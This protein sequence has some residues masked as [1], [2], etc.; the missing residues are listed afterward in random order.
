MSDINEL[1][2]TLKPYED[3]EY[4]MWEDIATVIRVLIKNQYEVSIRDDDVN[5]IVL[6]YNKEDPEYGLP[7]I[8][9]MT[10]DD[11]YKCMNTLEEF[12]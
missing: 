1:I 8:R 10:D 9:W 2:F 4:E 11:F 7:R 3:N 6:D 12:E 5:I